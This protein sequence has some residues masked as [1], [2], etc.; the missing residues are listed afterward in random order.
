M[1]RVTLRC[2]PHAPGAQRARRGGSRHLRRVR[3]AANAGG[4][5]CRAACFPTTGAPAS[6]AAGACGP[7]IARR[8]RATRRSS[9][10]HGRCSGATRPCSGGCSSGKPS[11]RP[12]AT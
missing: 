6:P 11:R 9:S 1:A 10:R 4:R 8:C 5:L 3:R 2:R 7:R 12:G